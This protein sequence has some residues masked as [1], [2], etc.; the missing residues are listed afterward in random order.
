MPLFVFF[1]LDG[2][3]IDHE[4]AARQANLILHQKLTGKIQPYSA[5]SERYAN[6]PAPATNANSVSNSDS[7]SNPEISAEQAGFIARFE[8]TIASHLANSPGSSIALAGGK[9]MQTFFAGE[10]FDISEG[11][12]QAAF[13]E[14]MRNYVDACFTFSDVHQCLAKLQARGLPL[15]IISN[16]DRETQSVKIMLNYLRPCFKTTVFSGD[17]GVS[18]PHAEIFNHACK[19][20]EREN[21]DC[22]FVGD[23]L[24]ADMAGAS[25]AGLRAIWLDRNK[26]N[27]D[28]VATN[29]TDVR[30]FERLETLEALPPLLEEI[31]AQR[32]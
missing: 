29:D 15:G 3:L 12:A 25:A 28:A 11:E 31:I 5:S 9:I 7:A 16:G 8:S 1:D 30:F 26:R 22:L 17:L 23:D 18:K 19:L 14:H 32:R 13:D 4:N 10:G 24:E 27:K 20:A 21:T 2:T 6:A